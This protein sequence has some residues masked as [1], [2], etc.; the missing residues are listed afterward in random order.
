MWSGITQLLSNVFGS[1]MAALG[2]AGKRSDLNNS[3]DVV[4]AKKGQEEAREVDKE[5]EAVANKDI[6]EIRKNLS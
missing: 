6:D 3:P 1:V 4:N 2:L 5:K